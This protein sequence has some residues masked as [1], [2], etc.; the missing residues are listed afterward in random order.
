MYDPAR[1][2][3]RIACARVKRTGSKKGERGRVVRIA[4]VSAED[5]DERKAGR[6]EGRTDGRTEKARGRGCMMEGRGT[7]KKE[8]GKIRRGHGTTLLNVVAHPSVVEPTL[9]RALCPVL[10]GISGAPTGPS[11]VSP[12]I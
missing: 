2:V 10:V 11:A 4:E 7:E 8:K 3:G 5:E 6:Q 12:I 1:L 9:S